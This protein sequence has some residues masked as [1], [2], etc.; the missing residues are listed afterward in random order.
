M[1][2]KETLYN[3]LEAIELTNGDD[4]IIITLFGAHVVSWKISGEEQI[5]VSSISKFD[6]SK[7]IRG[8]IPLVFPQFSRPLEIMQQHG[9]ARNNNWN[10]IIEDND[11]E[12]IKEGKVSFE[13]TENE[14]TLALYPHKFRLVYSLHLEKNW[15]H[16]NFQVTNTGDSEMKCHTLLHTYFKLKDSSETIIGGFGNLKYTSNIDKKEYL[17]DMETNRIDKE[18]DQMYKNCKVNNDSCITIFPDGEL[19]TMKVSYA[20][21]K[22]SGMNDSVS[23]SNGSI[24]PVPVDVVFWNGWV[25]KCKAMGDMD[26]DAYKHYVCIEPG[27]V[28]DWV[29]LNEGEQL[30]LA[31]DLQ[32][33]RP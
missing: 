20:A 23:S 10:R 9:F 26:D 33:G 13:L 27:T 12:K 17:N 29:V 30:T 28:A 16:L 2:C 4:S 15:L 3:G 11:L 25:D 22:E 32:Y 19:N 6:K 24:A 31:C 14:S 18:I 1:T 8:G 21:Q 7:A 5:F